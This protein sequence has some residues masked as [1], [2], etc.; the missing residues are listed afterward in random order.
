MIN[1]K[2]YFL[3]IG[4]LSLIAGFFTYSALKR[5]EILGAPQVFIS[6]PATTTR[7]T[8]FSFTVGTT[9]PLS[10]YGSTTLATYGSTTI[11]T[12]V[13]TLHAFRIINSASSTIFS[14]DTVNASSTIAGQFNAQTLTVTSCTGCGGGSAFAWTPSA[15]GNSTSTLIIFNAGII[16]NAASSTIT[17]LVGNFATTTNATS[18]NFNVSG[19]LSLGNALTVANGGTGLSTLTAAGRLL[20]STSATV[21]TTLTAGASSTILTIDGTTPAWTAQPLLTTLRVSGTGTSTQLLGGLELAGNGL[22]ISGT[23]AIWSSSGATS[24]LAGGINV[25]TGCFAVSGTCVGGG[26]GTP[27]GSNTQL[28]YNNSSAFGGTAEFTYAASTLTVSSSGTFDASAAANLLVPVSASSTITASGQVEIDTGNAAF[29]FRSGT[30]EYVLPGE[31]CFGGT[32]VGMGSE[33]IAV[34]NLGLNLPFE[35]TEIKTKADI[36]ATTTGKANGTG[37]AYSGYGW[38][39]HVMHG[40]SQAASSTATTASMATATS[41]FNS[42]T[43]FNDSS[44][45]ADEIWWVQTVSASSTA[46]IGTSTVSLVVKICGRIAP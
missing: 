9:T 15:L 29:H 13:N 39:F 31:K 46:Q 40:A 45:A 27:G 21:L 32:F 3:I 8:D 16:A 6:T 10:L 28:Q 41:T 37:Q 38:Q 22:N 30:T 4:L 11:Q 20:Y 12:P 2:Q 33:E 14:V 44:A 36:T 25:T 18:T 19:T 7:S 42:Y 24:T 1:N 35:I 23:G 5:Q 34:L 43:S 26:G 17:N